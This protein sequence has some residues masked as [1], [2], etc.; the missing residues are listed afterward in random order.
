MIYEYQKR[1]K[2]NILDG[3]IL[4][5]WSDIVKDY[6]EISDEPEL[7]KSEYVRFTTEEMRQIKTSYE[8]E[9]IYKIKKI[10][11][12]RVIKVEK[13]NIDENM[14]NITLNEL[15]A[16]EL[17]KFLCCQNIPVLQHIKYQIDELLKLNTG[18]DLN[19]KK[20]AKTN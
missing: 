6:I 11:G 4:V 12:G 14:L 18:D 7:K 2:K 9:K 13:E 19:D 10:F 20:N 15:E 5:I 3:K 17:Y 8:A 1:K 16:S